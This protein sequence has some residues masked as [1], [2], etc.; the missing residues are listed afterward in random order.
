ML[1]DR[2]ARERELL[3]Q[4]VE[5]FGGIARHNALTELL[6]PEPSA[7]QEAA[8]RVLYNA[9][10]E[11]KRLPTTKQNFFGWTTKNLSLGDIHRMIAGYLAVLDEHGK[12]LPVEKALEMHPEKD[13]HN[14]ITLAFLPLIG[15]RLVV[16]PAGSS[17]PHRLLVRPKN[18]G[19][20]IDFVLREAGHPLH[21]RNITKGIKDANFDNKRVLPETVH[22]ELIADG[23]FALVGRGLYGLKEW[24]MMEG[25]VY[26]V[27]EQVLRKEDRPMKVEEVVER[28]SLLRN[29]KK[30]TIVVNL[31]TKPQFKK[32]GKGMYTFDD[33]V[34]IPKR[35]RRKPRLEVAEKAP[36]AVT[37]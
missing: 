14:E 7:Q 10:P 11:A 32:Q 9:I 3:L 18:I 5:A 19:D 34:E 17:K 29:V 28:V 13:S 2:F 1:K 22:N 36:A 25:P 33:T 8:L 20:K 31:Q 30:G 16:F 12:I 23:R 15:S 21:F 27:I 26:R 4:A 24:H 35:R 37:A 6:V